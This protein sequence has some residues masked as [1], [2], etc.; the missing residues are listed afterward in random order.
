MGT[1]GVGAMKL[2]YSLG[3]ILMV[4]ICHVRGTDGAPSTIILKLKPHDGT[5]SSEEF[6]LP[7]PVT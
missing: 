3:C 5:D 6:L 1:V 4:S 2:S 7:D